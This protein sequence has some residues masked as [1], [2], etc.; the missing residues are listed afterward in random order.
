M[1]ETVI[2]TGLLIVGLAILGAQV[3]EAGSA[4]R[5]MERRTRALMLAE[6]QL[7]ELEMGVVELESADEVEELDFGP[8]HPDW[9]WRLITEPTSID[10]MVLARLDIMYLRREGTY[11]EDDFDHDDAEIVHTLYW[12]RSVPKPLDFT[13]D[14]GLDEEELLELNEKLSDLGLDGIDLSDFDPRYFQNVDFEELMTSLPLILKAMNIDYRQLLGVLP[15]EIMKQLQDSGLLGQ[16]EESGGMD[17]GG[18]GN[19]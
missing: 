9:G 18:G 2:A 16:L 8:R 19:R 1:L 15:P 11:R 4:V 5:K 10:E 7:A 3:Q 12:M 6:Q 13:R 14:F 17:G